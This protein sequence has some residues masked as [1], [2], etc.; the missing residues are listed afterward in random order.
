MTLRRSTHA[1]LGILVLSSLGA[2]AGCETDRSP[3]WYDP[4][5]D[6]SYPDEIPP[7]E[8]DPFP[9]CSAMPACDANIHVDPQGPALVITDPVV[10]A[11]VPLQR[12]VEQINQQSGIAMTATETMQRLFDTMNDSSAG[13]FTD[14]F[15]CDDIGSP[16]FQTKSEDTFTCPRAEGALASTDAF[17]QQGHPDSFFPVA[18]VNRFDLTTTDGTR[19][20]QYRVIYAKQSGLT[21]PNNRVFLIFEAS[22]LS[23]SPGCLESCRPLATY[24]KDLEGRTSTEI[25]D[26]IDQLFFVGLEGFLPVVH[27]MHYGLG[28]DDTGYG[29]HEGGQVRVSMHMEDPWDMR[30]MRLGFNGAGDQI[31]F[32]PTTVKNNPAASSFDP[33]NPSWSG[34]LVRNEM[35]PMSLHTLAAGELTAIQMFTPLEANA[36]ESVLGGEK[37]SDFF[38]AAT[39]AGDTSFVETI[40]S[41][42]E[43]SGFGADCPVDDPLDGEAILKRATALSCAGCHAPKE[44]LGED[45]GIGCGLTWPD[46]IGQS[47]VTEKSELSPALTEVFLPHRAKV[48]ETFLQ[49]CDMDAILGGL[50]SSD[51]GMKSGVEMR[52]APGRTL[53]GSRTH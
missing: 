23:P 14:G 11:K 34:E 7:D 22:M 38:T 5:P 44:M 12:V 30:E 35:I 36:V 39:A 41:M 51:G 6:E 13:K 33:T 28:A 32:V 2:L 47:H 25:A 16:A 3:G 45:R 10:L 9:T 18:I 31:A 37:K 26:R 29:G 19:C 8:P 43:G 50:Q 15:H 21:D 52:R 48:M 53:G 49:A 42:L 27:P 4:Y 40:D 17:F 1:A 24:L 46:S 20:G